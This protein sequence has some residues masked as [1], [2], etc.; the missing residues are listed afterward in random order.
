MEFTMDQIKGLDALATAIVR[1]AIDDYKLAYMAYLK[2]GKKSELNE[3][4][5]FFHGQWCRSLISID[6]A[7]II[8]KVEQDCKK[9]FERKK[10]RGK[11]QHKNQVP[12]GHPAH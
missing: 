5:N 1:R 3:L 8:E 9:K 6:P 12:S 7:L 11:S 4:R 10:N 2:T